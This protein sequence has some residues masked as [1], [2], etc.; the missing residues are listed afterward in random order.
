[1]K[2]A[3]ERHDIAGVLAKFLTLHPKRNE[4]VT[5][6][7]FHNDT[8]PSMTVVPKKQ[9][10]YCPVCAAKGDWI[11]FVSRYKNISNV[12]A[13][14]LIETNYSE[15][16]PP[17]P[18]P[19]QVEATQ[20]RPA[21]YTPKKIKHLKYGVPSQIWT[22]YTSKGELE[23]YAC[24]FDHADGT[25]DVL[26]YYMF[27]INGKNLWQWNAPDAPRTPYNAHLINKY[28]TS[29]IIVVEGEKTC[30]AVNAQLDPNKSICITSMGGG[31]AVHLTDWSCLN[32]RNV[33]Q[34]PDNDIEGL[35]A[36]L[37]IRY[38]SKAAKYWIVPL[39]HTLLKG[40]DAADKEWAPGELSKYI[41]S[42]MVANIPPNYN[43]TQWKFNQVGERKPGKPYEYIFGPDDKGKWQYTPVPVPPE[44]VELQPLDELPDNVKLPAVKSSG[45]PAVK[46]NAVKGA[47]GPASDD[48]PPYIDD[49]P[50]EEY[51]LWF[52]FMGFVKSE[53]SQTFIFFSKRSN[54]LVS[55]KAAGLSS[56]PALLQL[57]PL[58]FWLDNFEGK[59]GVNTD[60]V[61]D[62][63][64]NKQNAIGIFSP[65]HVRGRGAW[66]EA[67]GT[68]IHAGN[69]I[70][71]DNHIVPLEN[72]KSSYVYEAGA[73]LEFLAAKP[74]GNP[75]SAKLLELLKLANWEREIN[76]YL[77]AGWIVLAP[78]CGALRWRPHVWLTGG[79][80]TGKSWLLKEVARPLLGNIGHAMQDIT[81]SYIRQKLRS[82]AL[83]IVIDEMEGTTRNAANRVQ[84][85]LEVVRGSSSQ[86]GGTG[87]RGS[88]TGELKEYQIRSMFAFASIAVGLEQK[89]DISRVTVLN[90]IELH[91]PA[92]KK[93]R[94]TKLQQMWAD[95]VTD[96]W[97]AGMRA[98]TVSILPTILKNIDVFRA[99]AANVLG[100]QRA[101][102]Q[103]GTLLAGA[104]SVVSSKEITIEAAE[105]WIRSQD[106]SDAVAV[107]QERDEVALWQHITAKIV[108]VD[109]VVGESQSVVER[110]I[111]ELIGTA[112]DSQVFADSLITSPAAR[113]RLARF[114]I[115]A[116]YLDAHIWISI[117]HPWIKDLLK[118]TPWAKG[119]GDVLSRIKGAKRGR[120]SFASVVTQAVGVPVGIMG[121]N[122]FD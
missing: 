61:L 46:S 102:D 56:I 74:L 93:Q 95:V 8:H 32:G 53:T 89:S 112:I 113:D 107:S 38:I 60:M 23:G 100:R 25:K 92:Q 70:I 20:V 62:W 64:I 63:I 16:P 72:F 110:T 41:G 42:L 47:P 43:E 111:G 84:E 82:D 94:W 14:Q 26:P 88:G 118:D 57:A 71:K 122:F 91:D 34:W 52:R 65:D 54:T 76:P 85:V 106:M 87:G 13:V 97:C 29:N 98:R 19:K 30:D 51:E 37:H 86:D 115:K 35:A 77:L 55:A 44:P 1:M 109:D 68:I 75:D 80:G 119:Y 67:G 27:Y 81:A 5:N 33:I 24:R 21:T 10:F 50:K 36:M 114:G 7:P 45:V 83:P 120:K 116:D 31:K 108:R 2:E 9:I 58:S 103:V 22:Y 12:E 104:Y 40:W 59:R 6:C 69:Y 90:M 15:L 101:G 18:Q 4:W 48:A 121:S 99:A 39:N 17:P 105:K 28:A 11:D 73:P 66:R 79:A 117:Q 96:D 78:V 49:Q 3:K